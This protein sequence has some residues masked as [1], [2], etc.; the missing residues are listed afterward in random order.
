MTDSNATVRS[1]INNLIKTCKDGQEGFRTAAAGVEDPTIK[2]LL[3]EFSLQ[4]SAFA[5]ELQEAAI[6]LG[7]H[8]PAA[9]GSV[10]GAIHRGW[11][12]LKEAIAGKDNR[13]ILEECEAGEDVA[14][15]AYEKALELSLPGDLED[16]VSR[17]YTEVQATHDQVKE[18]RDA[19]RAARV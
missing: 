1:A 5:G 13:R 6:H 3:S 18:L 9:S 4:R 8:D 2:E 16:I 15:K 14:V 11:I 19:A 12:N 10:G 17:Q 7:E